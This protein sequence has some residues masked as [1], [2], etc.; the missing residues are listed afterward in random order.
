MLQTG[1][2]KIRHVGIVL[3]RPGFKGPWLQCLVDIGFPAL[4][5]SGADAARPSEALWL[6]YS[7]PSKYKMVN[8]C[9]PLSND[10]VARN[11]FIAYI[12]QGLIRHN[13]NN[14][15]PP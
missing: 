1:K 6:A 2:T 8:Q 10:R 14:P 4:V 7:R 13:A 12:A 9:P 11:G 5:P 15:R 3:P